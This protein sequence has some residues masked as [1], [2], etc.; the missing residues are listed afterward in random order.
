M[1]VTS[2]PRTAPWCGTTATQTPTL[3]P[4]RWAAAAAVSPPPSHEDPQRMKSPAS[5]QEG[6]NPSCPGTSFSAWNQNLVPEA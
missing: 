4:G 1:A 6:L 5:A 2:R 3:A